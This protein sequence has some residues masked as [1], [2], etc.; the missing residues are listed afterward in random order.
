MSKLDCSAEAFYSN[1]DDIRYFERLLNDYDAKLRSFSA[2]LVSDAN[3]ELA[4]RSEPH[5]STKS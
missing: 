5:N 2:S 3:S 1:A 4:A